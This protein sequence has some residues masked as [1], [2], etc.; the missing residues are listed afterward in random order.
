MKDKESLHLKVQDLC[1]CF[2]TTDPLKERSIVKDGSEVAAKII[3]S[4]IGFTHLDG[5]E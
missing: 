5:G 1:N 3:D 2:A 4:L